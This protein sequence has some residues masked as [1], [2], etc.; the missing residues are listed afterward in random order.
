MSELRDNVKQWHHSRQMDI[1][2]LERQMKATAINENNHKSSKKS[3]AASSPIRPK[4]VAAASTPKRT[5]R[6]QARIQEGDD[7]ANVAPSPPPQWGAWKGGD[8]RFND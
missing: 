8:I 5:T 7:S 6:S 1:A 2:E 3:S 4:A